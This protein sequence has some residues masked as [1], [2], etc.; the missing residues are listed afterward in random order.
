MNCEIGLAGNS[1]LNAANLHVIMSIPNCDF[2]EYWLPL[3][4]HQ[5]GVQEEITV[6]DRGVLDAPMKPGLGYDLDEEWI[7]SHKVVTLEAS[8]S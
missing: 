4:A 1:L 2:Y 6:N 5:W 3:A 8:K 7:A